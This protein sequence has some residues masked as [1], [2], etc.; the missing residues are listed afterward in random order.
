MKI[1]LEQIYIAHQIIPKLI[2]Q[3]MPIRC[4]YKLGKL[5]KQIESEFMLVETQRRKAV[6]KYG[7]RDEEEK[8]III[9]NPE[10]AQKFQQEFAS[11]LQEETEISFDPV[12]LD[13]LPD[14]LKLSAQD[15]AAIDIF[16]C[17]EKNE[18]ETT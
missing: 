18:K 12:S 10:N 8:K 5:A 2:S 13:E 17:G 15:M 14:E 3:E 9:K 16:F 6:E 7:E 11:L 4:A 1:K